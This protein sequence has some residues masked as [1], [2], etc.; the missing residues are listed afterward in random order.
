MCAHLSGE[1]LFT[2]HTERHNGVCGPL[3]LI[4]MSYYSSPHYPFYWL[5]WSQP[6]APQSNNKQRVIFLLSSH[7]LP[8]TGRRTQPSTHLCSWF[9]DPSCVDSAA[10]LKSWSAQSGWVEAFQLPWINRFGSRGVVKKTQLAARKRS[11]F[12]FFFKIHTIHN[13]CFYNTKRA[14]QKFK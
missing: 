7:P 10:I 13:M 5:V 8:H 1:P 6:A 12:Q 4:L 11:C 14:G 3:C 2:Q 9:I